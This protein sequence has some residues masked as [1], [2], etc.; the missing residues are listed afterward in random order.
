MLTANYLK[1]SC[2]IDKVYDLSPNGA[3]RFEE[4]F[5][6]LWA[7]FDEVQDFLYVPPPYPQPL[8]PIPS[9]NLVGKRD[10]VSRFTNFVGNVSSQSALV[11]NGI[12]LYP[13]TTAQ[14]SNLSFEFTWTGSKSIRWVSIYARV[15]GRSR[16]TLEYDETDSITEYPGNCGKAV[17]NGYSS[18]AVIVASTEDDYTLQLQV[19]ALTLPSP[20]LRTKV[21]LFTNGISVPLYHLIQLEN[22]LYHKV[23][24]EQW[25][26]VNSLVLK[27]VNEID[28]INL[29]LIGAPA[30]DYNAIITSTGGVRPQSPVAGFWSYYAIPNVKQTFTY[31]KQG[32]D[33]IV[34]SGQ[35]FLNAQKVFN[36]DNY[37]ALQPIVRLGSDVDESWRVGQDIK[38]ASVIFTLSNLSDSVYSTEGEYFVS[39][40]RRNG[41]VYYPY[42]TTR[43]FLKKDFDNPG[44]LR[45]SIGLNL[46]YTET[47]ETVGNIALRFIGFPDNA[48]PLPL[49]LETVL[50]YEVVV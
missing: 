35:D 8:P 4:K 32:N 23:V 19:R 24:E 7:A 12:Y 43:F 33:P 46:N 36:Q 27:T 2:K 11:S 10:P 15:A 13:Y 20:P 16:Y 42:F 49:E 45:G 28:A 40:C 21:C 18:Y 47:I 6:A 17:I 34:I 41:S 9:V 26:Y 38:R 48:D 31:L 44:F 37:F 25:R 3:I 29:P 30:D 39:L 5:S 1:T 22:N 14:S 50:G